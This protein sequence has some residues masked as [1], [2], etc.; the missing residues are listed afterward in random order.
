MPT[1]E[2]RRSSRF[3]LV[4]LL[5]AVGAFLYVASPFAK[6]VLVALTFA[7][8]LNPVHAWLTARLRG[9][10]SLSAAIVALGLLLAI[11]GPLAY[12]GTVATRQI[13]AGIRWLREA[14]ASEGVA[15]LVERLPES[16]QGLATRVAADLPELLDR[17]KGL[18][19]QAGSA[20]AL[21]G[22]LSATGGIVVGLFVMVVA[23]YFVLEQGPKL[24]EWLD[25][26]TPLAPG[27]LGEFLRSFHGAVVAVVVSTVATAGVQAALATLGYW[28]AG[29]PN[30]V[31]FGL[32]TFVSGL[33]PVVGPSLV[34]LP[35]CAIWYATGHPVSGI[36]LLVWSVGAVSGVDNVLKPVLIR[37]G[38]SVHISLIFLS[39]LGG[40]ASF[41]PIGLI[42]GPLALAFFIS[43][44]RIWKRE[45]G[46]GR[47]APAP[48]TAAPPLP[49]S[50]P[51]P[52]SP[53]APPGGGPAGGGG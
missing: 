8:V 1:N 48:A 13:L 26:I 52:G 44:L 29:V 23:L 9:R 45:Y 32:A 6:P 35:L 18:A 51:A 37:R 41:G 21:G 42:V 12:F 47:L 5:V 24:L 40:L 16:L 20:S 34:T 11:A 38:L 19:T 27:Q 36:L 10:R 53:G 2:P 30:P 50:G 4:V 31:F 39:L 15:G 14:L 46:G 28:V 33:I 3:F 43:A 7:A 49:D 22:I 25:E 17:V